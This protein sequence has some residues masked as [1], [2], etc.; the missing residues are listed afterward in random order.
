MRSQFIRANGGSAVKR[1]KRQKQKLAGQGSKE[2]SY[3]IIFIIHYHEC[4]IRKL[5]KKQIR[6][7]K[8]KERKGP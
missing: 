6:K 7:G 1:E 5:F 2:S 8:K 4:Q 3:E